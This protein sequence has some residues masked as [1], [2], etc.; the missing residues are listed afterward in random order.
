MSLVLGLACSHDLVGAL[1]FPETNP[2]GTLMN[3]VNQSKDEY[4]TRL[5]VGCTIPGTVSRESAARTLARPGVGQ[6]LR[7]SR[8]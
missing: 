5:R 1:A 2:G 8:R 6:G 3:P 7:G 4:I